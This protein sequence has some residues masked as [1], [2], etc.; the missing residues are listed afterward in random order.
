MPAR[1]ELN[2][3]VPQRLAAVVVGRNEGPK[4][5]RCLSSVLDHAAPIVFADSG[6]DDGSAD[7]ARAMGAAVVELDRSAPFTAG[8]GRNEGFAA[9]LQLEPDIAYVQFVDG[10]SEMIGSWF[11]RARSALDKRPECAVVFGRHRERFAHKSRVTRLYATMGDP[12]LADPNVCGGIA[13]MRVA[14]FRQVGGFNP[15]M[16]NLEDREL[17]LRLQRAG[18]KVARL[19]EEM[20]IHEVAMDRFGQWWRRHIRGGHSRAHQVALHGYL[21][22]HDGNREFSRLS[23]WAV[24][25]FWSVWFWGVALPIGAVAAAWPTCGASLVLFAGYPALF[26]SIYRRLHRLGFSY[27]DAGLYATAC[28]LAKFPQAI[29]QLRFHLEPGRAH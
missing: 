11:E 29:G 20:A 8:R 28:V 18:W 14:A 7:L 5:R 25:E 24:R 27:A 16:L 12:R 1:S 23:Y 4:L 17:C 6:S 21:P 3:R 9:A 26:Y 13:M 10:D 2:G 22:R 15:T 19:D